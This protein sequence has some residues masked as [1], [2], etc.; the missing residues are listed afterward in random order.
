MS[1]WIDGWV[2]GLMGEWVGGLMGEWVGGWMGEWVGGWVDGWPENAANH[3]TNAYIVL[4][5]FTGFLAWGVPGVLWK[6]GGGR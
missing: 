2:G 1:G 4:G 3:E 6:V 5:S